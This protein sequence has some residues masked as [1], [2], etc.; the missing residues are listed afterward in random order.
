[1]NEH[2]WQGIQLSTNRCVKLQRLIGLPSSLADRAAELFEAVRG[3]KVSY[4]EILCSQGDPATS[5]SLAGLGLTILV[6]LDGKKE[7]ENQD[8]SQ[9]QNPRSLASE[10]AQANLSP[11]RKD[12]LFKNIL[13][14]VENL[15]TDNLAH[16]SIDMHNIWVEDSV[17]VSIGAFNLTT[18]L[19]V[20]PT[21]V[22]QPPEH[23]FK[24]VEQ[25]SQPADLWAV[26]FAS[27]C[28]F[29]GPQFTQA[30][31]EIK[32]EHSYLKLILLLELAK[33]VASSLKSDLSEIGELLDTLRHRCTETRF[34]EHFR[35]DETLSQLQGIF[36]SQKSSRPASP[37]PECWLL[38]TLVQ[39]FKT[40]PQLMKLVD[41][42]PEKRLLDKHQQTLTKSP[43]TSTHQQ[44]TQT[45]V[46]LA[47]RGSISIE[48]T[49]I[50][51]YLVT[52][53]GLTDLDLH[54]QPERFS[55][56]VS[57]EG[58]CFSTL[59]ET[60]QQ[61]FRTQTENGS[62]R[63]VVLMKLQPSNSKSVNLEANESV[64]VILRYWD[65][66]S[67][68]LKKS[69]EATSINLLPALVMCQ[70]KDKDAVLQEG[71]TLLTHSET[72]GA[73]SVRYRATLN[74]INLET[75]QILDGSDQQLTKR[76]DSSSRY[77]NS[78]PPRLNKPPVERTD[79]LEA[80]R[81]SVNKVKGQIQLEIGGNREVISK[82]RSSEVGP[83]PQLS[84][85]ITSRPQ[86]KNTTNILAHNRD[87]ASE[88]L[89]ESILE[90]SCKSLGNKSPYP[91]VER[92]DRLQRRYSSGNDG[93][94]SN[95]NPPPLQHHESMSLDTSGQEIP[96]IAC[97][98]YG[99]PEY[100][101]TNTSTR[102][103]A[104]RA[105]LR[106]QVPKSPSIIENLTRENPNTSNLMTEPY[107][108]PIRVRSLA[109]GKEQANSSP[110]RKHEPTS[111]NLRA[112]IQELLNT[113]SNEFLWE[114]S[115][116][117]RTRKSNAAHPEVTDPISSQAYEPLVSKLKDLLIAHTN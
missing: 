102:R 9:P 12:L 75:P 74:Q 39:V 108:D 101:T 65:K 84:I 24:S 19:T 63:P 6:S 66:E 94:L 105:F 51:A 44:P 18:G 69:S 103:Q 70:F 45:D 22:F 90:S 99:D 80:A 7:F 53:G 17:Y 64:R 46:K 73:V 55:C 83:S 113:Y 92:R 40:S 43:L 1:M 76:V 16:G 30:V 41:W 96:K 93:H 77:L 91:N 86:P 98:D 31:M 38:S 14:C 32:E 112:E 95:P 48:I 56:L 62:I 87:I 58:T 36:S 3:S 72:P 20:Q 61:H 109:S 106:S 37:P 85:K 115:T 49:L 29:S 116:F 60:H 15:H 33:L 8:S 100:T 104:I 11:S 2:T 23:V 67:R 117:S 52:S 114:A 21:L 10:V 110:H 13:V 111:T 82:R 54:T 79:S 27:L 25:T 28:L 5:G 47:C 71:W 4:L 97:S 88:N 59:N 50:E 81:P 78:I 34:L 26:G 68:A 107:S 42:D 35:Y 89:P 57:S